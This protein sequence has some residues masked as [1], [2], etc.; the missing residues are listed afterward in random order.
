MELEAVACLTTSMMPLK[1]ISTCYLLIV[2]EGPPVPGEIQTPGFY[3]RSLGKKSACSL[4]E[5]KAF[6]E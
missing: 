5:A 3:E 4:N 2:K 6:S 1:A